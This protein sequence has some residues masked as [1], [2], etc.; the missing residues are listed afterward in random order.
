MNTPNEEGPGPQGSQGSG[1]EDPEQAD[2]S[3]PDTVESGSGSDPSFCNVEEAR[4]QVQVMAFELTGVL[5]YLRSASELI[6]QL[7]TKIEEER[8]DPEGTLHSVAK[9]ARNAIE[10]SQRG[11]VMVEALRSLATPP[12]G[13]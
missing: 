5:V 2:R 13:W 1:R 8:V 11:A 12:R 3:E 10:M 4:E 9:Q 7:V 6:L